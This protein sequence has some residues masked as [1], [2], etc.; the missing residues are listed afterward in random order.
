MSRPTT[1]E[2]RA[3][4]YPD[5]RLADDDHRRMFEAEAAAIERD[6]AAHR[7]R[8]SVLAAHPERED[9]GDKLLRY[10]ERDRARRKR[11][12]SN[13]LTVNTITIR[14]AKP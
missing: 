6:A 14:R 1:S 8:R 5:K 12:L 2:D 4:Y 9:N 10:L 11:Y 13:H 7:R 3:F